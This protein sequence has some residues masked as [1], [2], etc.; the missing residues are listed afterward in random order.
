MKMPD[1]KKLQR[2]ENIQYNAPLST[3]SIDQMQRTNREMQLIIYPPYEYVIN[4][5]RAATCG[6]N[7]QKPW[8]LRLSSEQETQES[9][10]C[11]P[12]RAPRKN[13]NLESTCVE[14]QLHQLEDP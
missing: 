8:F 10:F 9:Q 6:T 4:K 14:R 13:L 2:K 7:L 11:P 1:L 5:K 12:N 3:Y